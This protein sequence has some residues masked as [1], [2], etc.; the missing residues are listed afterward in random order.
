MLTMHWKDRD[1]DQID[2][3]EFDAPDPKAALKL[4]R[5][6]FAERFHPY[7]GQERPDTLTLVKVMEPCPIGK[8]YVD[9]QRKAKADLP[10]GPL[11][12][13][14]QDWVERER[15][16]GM[17]ADGFTLHTSSDECKRYIQNYNAKYN[18]EASVPD[19]YTQASGE[20]RLVEV[21]EETY[22]KV[23]RLGSTWGNGKSGPKAYM[24]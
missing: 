7:G 19:E 1:E 17:R 6:Y 18:N 16:W 9:L 20:P 11:L 10:A 24:P 21:D 5:E 4:A 3:H 12:L 13:V 8:W 22:L 15:G 2:H 23:Q 14:C